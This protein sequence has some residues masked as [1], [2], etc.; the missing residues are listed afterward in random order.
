MVT[1][2]VEIIQTNAKTNDLTDLGC[3]FCR[4]EGYADSQ[5]I[6]SNGYV[7]A[8]LDLDAEAADNIRKEADG[9]IIENHY[10]Y[11]TYNEVYDRES[12]SRGKNILE[13]TPFAKHIIVK[14]GHFYGVV[15]HIER[16]GGNGWSGFGEGSYCLQFTDGSIIGNNEKYYSFSG[17][18]RI[19]RESNKYY[20]KKRSE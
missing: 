11:Y 4:G 20:L 17:E 16:K 2:F 13:V 8:S 10:R 18:D 1:K 9:W 12:D 14:D 3:G 5:Y 6:E 7:L 19:V 15:I